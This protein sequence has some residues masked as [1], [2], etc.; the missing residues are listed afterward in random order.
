[1]G[2]GMMTKTMVG[3]QYSI[4][5]SHLRVPIDGQSLYFTVIGSSRDPK[6]G[7]KTSFD[8]NIDHIWPKPPKSNQK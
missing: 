3:D 5:L 7:L 8:C 2:A 1:M 4:L 6:T